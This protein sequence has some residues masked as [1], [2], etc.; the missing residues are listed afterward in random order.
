MSLRSFV[1]ASTFASFAL[2]TGCS[3][4]D[5]GGSSDSSNK[6]ASSTETTTAKADPATSG[7]GK[8]GSRLQPRWRVAEDGAQELVGWHD[9]DLDVKCAFASF[10]GEVDRCLPVFEA[11]TEGQ[12]DGYTY[13]TDKTCTEMLV[14]RGCDVPGVTKS[15]YSLKTTTETKTGTGTGG[16][17][18]PSNQCQQATVT[19]EISKLEAFDPSSTVYKRSTGA[20]SGACTLGTRSTLPPLFRRVPVEATKFVAAQVK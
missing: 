11:V 10:D 12:T 15:G 3:A 4:M 20:T 18:P 2:V 13:Y 17:T 8:A 19:R 5:S 1:L 16:T 14:T 9:A 7:H 6:P